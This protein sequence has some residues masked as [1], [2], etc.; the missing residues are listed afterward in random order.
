LLL[1][2][3][4][5][6]AADRL[7]N[8]VWDNAGE[9]GKRPEVVICFEAA[10]L[11]AAREFPDLFSKYS[12]DAL[13]VSPNDENLADRL[14]ETFGT[15]DFPR[16]K[17][18]TAMLLESWRRRKAALR[19]SDAA[20]LF[21]KSESD[22][23]PFLQRLSELYFRELANSDRLRNPFVVSVL[24]EMMDAFLQVGSRVSGLGLWPINGS[25]MNVVRGVEENDTQ[26]GEFRVYAALQLLPG[27]RAVDLLQFEGIYWA[28]GCPC[29]NGEPSLKVG[30]ESVAFLSDDRSLK[31]PI[32]LPASG[33]SLRYSRHLRP[34]LQKDTPESCDYGDIQITVSFREASEPEVITEQRIFKYLSGGILEPVDAIRPVPRLTDEDLKRSLDL[35]VIDRNTFDRLM[36]IDSVTRYMGARSDVGENFIHSPRDLSALRKILFEGC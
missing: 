16:P 28:N 34:P 29:L 10:C 36:E 2:F 18:L 22:I 7:L 25:G 19:P 24:Q 14:Q 21:E 13:A 3:V 4:G 31:H 33:A 9:L 17:E 27:D 30:D 11:A 26:N 20:P 23:R 35:A 12:T 15:R 6:W 8:A 32:R 1:E 5:K